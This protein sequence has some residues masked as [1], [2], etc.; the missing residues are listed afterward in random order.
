M[1]VIGIRVTTVVVAMD[2][3]PTGVEEVAERGS[4]Y[5]LRRVITLRPS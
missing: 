5:A 2:C 3:L 4:V 1:W